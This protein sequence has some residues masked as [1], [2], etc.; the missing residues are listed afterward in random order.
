MAPKI[1]GSNRRR[2]SRVTSRTSVT[3]SALDR[4]TA[5]ATRHHAQ[6]FKAGRWSHAKVAMRTS[7][8]IRVVQP[9]LLISISK[10]RRGPGD[11]THDSRIGTISPADAD[12]ARTL[13]AF[14]RNT[15]CFTCYFLR[16][17]GRRV[18]RGI[19]DFRHIPRR[20]DCKW[21]RKVVGD[22]IRSTSAWISSL[23]SSRTHRES[24]KRNQ[25]CLDIWK[26]L[27][28]T[29][30]HRP[31]CGRCRGLPL[32]QCTFRSTRSISSTSPPTKKILD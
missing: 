16:L 25:G 12:H 10:P 13:K 6:N 20:L 7:P 9:R 32:S 26:C 24:L 21:H 11:M 2:R 22:P 19:S 23:Q 18:V 14:V 15:L 28:S 29:T 31:R 1:S 30:E 27:P 3:R 17:Y 5:S 4:L 8:V